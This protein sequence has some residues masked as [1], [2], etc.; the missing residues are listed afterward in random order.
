[1]IRNQE[2]QEVW[3]YLLSKFLILIYLNFLFYKF[4][5]INIG[6]GFIIFKNPQSVEFVMK[7]KNSHSIRGKWIDCK[8]ATPKEAMEQN[9][10]NDN[11]K[12]LFL[13]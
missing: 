3:F 10:N 8:P 1:M 12:K 2:H 11:C 6:F 7:L 9:F 4:Y 13:Y 5:F